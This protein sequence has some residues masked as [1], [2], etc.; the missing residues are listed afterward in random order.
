ML[1]QFLSVSYQHDRVSREEREMVELLKNLPNDELYKIASGEPIEKLADCSENEEWLEKFRGS[2]L[3]EQAVQL[4]QQ[5]LM[6]DM[7]DV[8]KREQEA[9]EHAAE[10]PDETY[11]AKDKIRIQ[12]RMLELQLAQQT[13]GAAAPAAAPMAPEVGA[14]GAG[15]VGP[16]AAPVEANKTAAQLIAF[17]DNMGRELARQDFQKAAHAQHLEEIGKAAGAVMAKTAIDW[18]GLG[19]KALGAVKAHPGAA[20]GAGLG[21]AGGL[22]HGL[23]KDERGE[24][25][26][27]RGALEGAAGG[28]A[29]AG[30]GAGVQGVASRMSGTNPMKLT[31]ALK[32]TTRAGLE[33]VGIKAQSAAKRLV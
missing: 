29:G 11:R 27:L 19:T 23:Q 25:H 9:A 6:L 16:E 1:D 5:E 8:Q 13:L 15:A 21:A 10:P 7:A 2:P 12:K 18:A 31:E 17:A 26:L 32:D 22:A 3:L 20:I 30:L 4:A 24:R 14:Q 33:G 28:A